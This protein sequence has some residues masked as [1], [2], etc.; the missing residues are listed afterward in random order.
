V[1]QPI[2]M[3]LNFALGVG[4]VAFRALAEG[5]TVSAARIARGAEVCVD[6]D[7]TGEVVGIELLGLDGAT[8]RLAADFARQN[9]LAFPRR[10]DELVPA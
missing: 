2:S 5:E 6:R 7:A 10:I 9:G 4:Y 1:R 8:L 3:T